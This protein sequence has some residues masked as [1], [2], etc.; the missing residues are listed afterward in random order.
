MSEQFLISN[1]RTVTD[2]KIDGIDNLLN[3]I[4][5]SL[6]QNA[7]GSKCARRISTTKKAIQINLSF[8]EGARQCLN[9]KQSRSR[10]KLAK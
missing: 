1:E 9:R 4:S 8:T 10:T 3:I 2:H 7:S 6:P 5:K